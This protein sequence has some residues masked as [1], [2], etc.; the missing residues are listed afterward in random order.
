MKKVAI[1]GTL[2]VVALLSL[3]WFVPTLAA[4]TQSQ[5][6]THQQTIFALEH[7]VGKPG[8]AAIGA[9]I[10][11]LPY[12]CTGAVKGNMLI[13]VTEKVVND[14]DS[15]Q[16]GN[17]WAYD[18]F[19]RTIQVWNVGSDS[20][21]A[22]V[23]YAGTFAAVAGQ[24]SPGTVGSNGGILTGDEVGTIKGGY[25]M[26]ITASLDVSAPA[27]WPLVGKVNGGNAVDYQCVIAV[28]GSENCPGFVDWTAQY[29]STGGSYNEDLWGWTYVG[30]DAPTAPDAGT[31][32][33]VWHNFYSGNSG[34]IL[35]VD[36]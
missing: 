32:D 14:G 11:K 24:K 25:H 35:D 6:T 30:K 5:H 18:T 34:D 33:G 17:Y 28:N 10:T 4:R 9:A 26:L 21:C 12:T 15:G 2:L 36:P 31:A 22:L 16:A 7:Q 1:S 20:Y 23:N 13:N 29:F 3:V 27:T 19:S 8:G